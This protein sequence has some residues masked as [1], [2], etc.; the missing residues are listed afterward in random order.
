M[1]GMFNPESYATPPAPEPASTDTRQER[2]EML[3]RRVEEGR[4][5]FAVGDVVLGHGRT[6]APR[7]EGCRTQKRRGPH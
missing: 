3:R 5:L 6:W 4:G 2:V 7:Q 1:G